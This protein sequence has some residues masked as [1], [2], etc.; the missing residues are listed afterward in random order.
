MIDTP[1]NTSVIILLVPNVTSSWWIEGSLFGSSQL[2]L[3]VGRAP[4]KITWILKYSNIL[5]IC[6][7][8]GSN[9]NSSLIKCK[10][11]LWFYIQHLKNKKNTYKMCS[12]ELI[13]LV[14]HNIYVICKYSLFFKF[15]QFNF[16][17]TIVSTMKLDHT[18]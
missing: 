10:L 8:Y 6:E 3:W 17:L 13:A 12:Y 2:E 15:F 11:G 1:S 16:N 18:C 5:Q 14:G 4:T 7:G 9:F